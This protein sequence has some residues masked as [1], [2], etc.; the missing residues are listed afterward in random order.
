MTTALHLLRERLN[1]RHD[2][3][4]LFDRVSGAFH[5]LRNTVA[6]NMVE[7]IFSGADRQTVIDH[8]SARYHVD[9]GRVARDLDMLV[10]ELLSPPVSDSGLTGP[11]G[12]VQRV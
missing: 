1:Y 5:R 10:A 4:L 8:V 6:R 11:R 12:S 3:G 9:S 7:Q 2:L